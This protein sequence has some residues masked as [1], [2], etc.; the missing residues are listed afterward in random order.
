MTD[1]EII[2]LFQSRSE[3]AIEALQQ[4]YS[5]LCLGIAR[6]ALG[7][8]EDAEECFSDVCLDV[9]NSI[10]PEEPQSLG[11]FVGKI[12]RRRAVD[13]FRRTTAGKRRSGLLVRFEELSECLADSTAENALD[14]M[15][16][17]DTLNAFLEAEAPEDRAMFVL[18]YWY[19]YDYRLVAKQLGTTAGRVRTRLCRMRS[20]LRE[21]LAA[22]GIEG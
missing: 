18:R 3:K 17:R 13:K 19:G 9:W 2:A 10:P 8:A 5:A 14:S 21:T 6:R 4:K 7:S 1:Q 20:R 15:V 11:A 12:T 22:A 16:L